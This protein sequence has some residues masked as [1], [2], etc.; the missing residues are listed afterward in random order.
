M[1]VSY[2]QWL[3]N[4]ETQNSDDLIVLRHRLRKIVL[5]RSHHSSNPQLWLD[6]NENRDQALDSLLD[7]C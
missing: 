3:H 1:D 7:V 2:L 5:A 6:K 4:L